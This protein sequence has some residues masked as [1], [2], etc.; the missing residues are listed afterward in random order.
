MLYS[1]LVV[2]FYVFGMT[3]AKEGDEC[4]PGCVE[5]PDGSCNPKK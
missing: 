3:L 4:A 1:K 2:L 5:G